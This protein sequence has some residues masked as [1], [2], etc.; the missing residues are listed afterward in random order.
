LRSRHRWL[1]D[2][3]VIDFVRRLIADE[4]SS[5]VGIDWHGHRDRGLEI[6][7]AL[8]AWSAGADRCHGTVLGVGERCGNVAIETLIVNLHLSG[9]KHF[10]LI[11]LATY[12]GRAALALGVDIPPN[13]PFFGPNAFR[14]ATG[15]HVAAI[16]EAL[17]VGRL[18]LAEQLFSCISP[19]ALNR[20]LVIEIGPLSGAATVATFLDHHGLECPPDGIALITET[21]KSCART[22]NLEDVRAIL[23][24][25]DYQIQS[26]RPAGEVGFGVSGRIGCRLP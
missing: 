22:L 5:G 18:D 10:D 2:T 23:K 1:R 11:A 13:Q 26:G 14:S 3:E 17:R 15:T 9:D 6:A 21:A 19:S 25:M 12:V 8:A 7:N 4:A 24:A 16:A 20:E